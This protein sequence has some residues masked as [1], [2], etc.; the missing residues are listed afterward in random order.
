MYN[1]CVSSAFFIAKTTWEL[2]NEKADTARE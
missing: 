2:A 1:T